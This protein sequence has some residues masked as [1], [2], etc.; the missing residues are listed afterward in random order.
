MTWELKEVD[1]VECQLDDSGVYVVINRIVE[2]RADG[3]YI[4]EF[5]KVR[6]D[7]MTA[8]NEPLVSFVGSANAV[9]KHLI[10][11]LNYRSW[12]RTKQF[13]SLEHASYIGY[14]LLRAEKQ[15]GFVQD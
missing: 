10:R 1:D 8:D 15:E 7:L 12:Q 6:A 14:E 4:R 11:F 3:D 2:R 9:R 13:I 5:V